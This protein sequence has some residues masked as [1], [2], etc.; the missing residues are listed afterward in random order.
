MRG[1][2]RILGGMVQ[3]AAGMTRLLGVSLLKAAAAAEK[4]VEA[5]GEDEEKPEPKPLQ[6]ASQKRVSS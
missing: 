6:R 5:S 2:L 4:V 1:G 3:L